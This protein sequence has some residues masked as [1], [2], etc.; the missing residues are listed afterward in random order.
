MEA[1]LTGFGDELEKLA[2]TK[3]ERD[4]EREQRALQRALRKTTRKAY[5]GTPSLEKLRGKSSPRQRD[6][7]AS[8]A[9]AAAGYPAISLLSATVGRKLRNRTTMNALKGLKIRDRKAMREK[10]ETGPLVAKTH[11]SK[12]PGQL[13]REDLATRAITGG[14]IG[15]LLQAMRDRFAGSTPAT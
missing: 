3:A 4:F 5:G 13:S 6:Y 8:G 9:L 2:K 14:A 1:L 7:L 10:L 12:N 15:S 11:L